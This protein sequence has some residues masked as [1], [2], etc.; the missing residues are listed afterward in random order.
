MKIN[1]NRII[2]KDLNNIQNLLTNVIQCKICMNILIDPVDC[3]Y[4][5]QT[6]CKNCINNYLKTNKNCPFDNFV[7]KNEE[8]NNNNN[9]IEKNSEKNLKPSSNNIKKLIDSLRLYCSYKNNGCNMELCLSE[10]NE[11]E[12]KCRFKNRKIMTSSIIN[13]NNSKNEKI[14]DFKKEDSCISFS[15]VDV[16]KIDKDNFEFDNCNNNCKDFKNVN[17]IANNNNIILNDIAGKI[18]FIYEKIKNFKDNNNNENTFDSIY[19]AKNDINIC[20]NYKNNFEKKNDLKH[21]NKKLNYKSPESNI[22]NNNDEILKIKKDEKVSTPKLGSHKKHISLYNNIPKINISNYLSQCNNNNSNNNIVSFTSNNLI[23]SE[24]LKREN[25]NYLKILSEINSL[26]KKIRT[27]EKISQANYSIENQEFL[28]QT[29]DDS[30]FSNS[31]FFNTLTNSNSS[32]DIINN[33]KNKFK[34]GSEKKPSMKFKKLNSYYSIS[35]LN[36]RK[37]ISSK[38]IN[39][40]NKNLNENFLEIFKK[41]I[42]ENFDNFEKFIDEK[43]VEELKK[44]FMDFSLDNTNLFVQK[45]DEVQ[46]IIKNNSNRQ[47]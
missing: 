40:K 22:N 2:F 8:K 35:N 20:H 14:K 11:H 33:V 16:S 6:F 25:N 4:C 32:Y 36:K 39:N 13:N 12:E 1:F 34:S 42:K 27:L 43:C 46:E 3:L 18:D 10:I 30:K 17:E 29:E 19:F 44:F 41:E 15:N 38:N 24:R 26:G 31:T 7:K 37:I 45:L 28:I 5:N 47:K 23:Q 21:S 9:K